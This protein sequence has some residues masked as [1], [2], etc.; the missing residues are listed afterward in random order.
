VPGI[1][2]TAFHAYGSHRDILCVPGHAKRGG[3]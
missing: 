1:L 2:A 3:V